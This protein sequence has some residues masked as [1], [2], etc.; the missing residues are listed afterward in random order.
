MTEL[1]P[2][3]RVASRGQ[4]FRRGG[5]AFTSEPAVLQLAALSLAQAIAIVGESQL[6]VEL[7]D[8]ETFAAPSEEQRSQIVA[9]LGAASAEIDRDTPLGELEGGF[10]GLTEMIETAAGEPPAPKRGKPKAKTE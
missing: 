4:R 6:I 10:A 7:G 2:S 3:L 1:T 9:H 8:G 5:L